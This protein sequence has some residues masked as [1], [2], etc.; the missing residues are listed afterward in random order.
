MTIIFYEMVSGLQKQINQLDL[1]QHIFSD[2][3]AENSHHQKTTIQS[4]DFL[5]KKCT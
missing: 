2:Q 3:L 5:M 1:E 4:D